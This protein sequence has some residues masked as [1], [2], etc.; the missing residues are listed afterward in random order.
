M[1]M[2]TGPEDE[3]FKWGMGHRCWWAVDH[4][5]F[6]E[7]A[8]GPV[9]GSWV[10]MGDWGSARGLGGFRTVTLSPG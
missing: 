2:V 4:F 8:P 5:D 6:R 9:V 3:H 1:C 7:P 10:V